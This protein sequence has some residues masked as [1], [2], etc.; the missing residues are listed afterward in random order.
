MQE[1]EL[2]K[3]AKK[4]P[5]YV[6]G[7][8]I[9]RMLFKVW[10]AYTKFIR[11]L[12]QS[13]K[14]AVTIEF[15]KFIPTAQEACFIPSSSFLA[16]GPFSYIPSFAHT[17]APEQYLSYSSVSMASGYSKQ[18]CMN[19]IKEIMHTTVRM[20]LNSEV[21]LDFKVGI[22]YIN[23]R[24]MK[25]VSSFKMLNHGDK[26]LLTP[27]AK[28]QVHPANPNNIGFASV[29][30]KRVR[31]VPPA[32][33]NIP[34]PYLSAFYDDSAKKFSKKI[35]VEEAL[36]P[37]QLLEEHKRQ[38]KEKSKKK[39]L[40]NIE[41]LYDGRILAK[42]ANSDLRNERE[43]RINHHK[44]IQKT[45]VSGIKDQLIEHKQV[46]DKNRKEKLDEKYDFFPFTYG[47]KLEEFQSQLKAQRKDEML[48]KL[49]ADKQ[50]FS[51]NFNL[52][53]SYLTSFPLFMKQ[54]KAYPSRRLENTHIKA[55]MGQALN[56]YEQELQ[57]IKQ[58]K[59]QQ[60][61]VEDQ[62]NEMDK[63]YEDQNKESHIK[64]VKDH[65]YY[66]L[67]QIEENVNSN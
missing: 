56:R 57:T 18:Q 14:S 65:Q 21:K 47:S 59:N 51:K 49:H 25:F 23:A 19:S 27:E 30:S 31:T 41:E 46:S 36:S 24:S 40:S 62:Q 22:L 38:I 60:E 34:W 16:L 55:V 29:T 6:S 17:Q 58:S 3:E 67:Q 28:D 39:E 7:E 63:I 53:E 43:Q 11:G 15:G 42:V 44:Q 37:M 45:F 10:S 33:E 8:D 66:L 12:L 13:G 32:P 35:N 52:P 4:N 5:K 64:A 20:A 61:V 54:D 9:V 2:F 48:D 26:R 1:M 50:N